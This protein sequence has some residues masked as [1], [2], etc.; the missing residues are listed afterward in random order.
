MKVHSRFNQG[1]LQ[2]LFTVD[3]YELDESMKVKCM[4]NSYPSAVRCIETIYKVFAQMYIDSKVMGTIDEFVCDFLQDE[5]GRF[6]FMKIH[7][8]TTDGVPTCFNDWRVSTKF[9]DRVAEKEEK[10]IANQVCHAKLLC[11]DQTSC[12]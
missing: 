7:D 5:Y 10:M 4:P 1:T 12:K 3:P 11:N 8:F 2:S 6:H 9:V